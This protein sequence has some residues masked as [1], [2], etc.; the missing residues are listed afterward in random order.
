M[1]KYKKP[2]LALVL[3]L[4]LCGI[5][6]GCGEAESDEGEV[7]GIKLSYTGGEIGSSLTAD[8]TESPLVFTA[9]VQA[10]GSASKDFTLESSVP[11]VAE[12]SGKTVNLLK[13]GQTRITGIASGDQSKKHAFILNV[14][15]YTPHSIT[16]TG[17][18][19][20]ATAVSGETVTLTP[21]TQAGRDFSDWTFDPPTVIMIS[22]NQ[23]IMPSV[24]V[25]VTG[26]FED[27][28]TAGKPFNITNNFGQDSSTELLAQWHNDSSL[29]TQTLQIVAAAA[30]FTGAREIP[31]TGEAFQGSSTSGGIGNYTLRNVF[32]AHVTDLSPA[33]LYKYRMGETGAWSA[34]FYHLTSGGPNRDFSFT[35]ATDPQN[36]EFSNMAATFRAAN[37]FDSDNRFFLLCGDLVNDTGKNLSEIA[38]YTSAANEFNVK[39][40]IAATQGNHDT[41]LNVSSSDS[42]QFTEATVFNAFVTFPRNGLQASNPT[43]SDSYY[44]YYNDVL[45]IMLNSMVS[46]SA[47]GH[48]AQVNWLTDILETNRAGKLSKYII[49]GTHVGP[50]SGRNVD[51]YFAS[52]MRQAYGKLVCDY[53]VDIFFSGHDHIYTR[54]NPIK[55]GTNIT[56]ST[57]DFSAQANG[58]YFSIVGSTGPKFYAMDAGADVPRAYP[59]I[60]Q[61]IAEQSPGVFVNVKVTGERLSVTAMRTG[62]NEIDH[63]EVEAKTR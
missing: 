37:A 30:S 50:F 38:D 47:A 36:G 18:T 35:V 24:D 48:A 33:T 19:A 32:R 22:A 8:L 41:Y 9:A 17:G 23:F 1:K 53:D 16:V 21:G 52:P 4:L 39:T 7:T 44:F 2:A 55:I 14:V 5:L 12:V 54:S 49:I 11:E 31:V 28:G 61:T 10:S 51:R 45:V 60:T 40:P 34:V 46:D 63:Y 56:Y 62:A 58:T 43:R 3:S 59:V 25:T 6:A 42:Y 13:A 15:D 20:K 26:N 29:A 27:A 57:M